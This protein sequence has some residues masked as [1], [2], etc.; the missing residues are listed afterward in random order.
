[1]SKWGHFFIAKVSRYP[2]ARPLFAD[3]LFWGSSGFGRYR[4]RFCPRRFPLSGTHGYQTLRH[5]GVDGEIARDDTWPTVVQVRV[6]PT[7]GGCTAARNHHF[8]PAPFSGHLGV[9]PVPT[10]VLPFETRTHEFA[11][12]QKIARAPWVRPGLGGRIVTGRWVWEF[13]TNVNWQGRSQRW[14]GVTGTR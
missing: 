14:P 11:L 6:R 5:W 8:L 13:Y 9:W 12:F 3:P 4:Q 7:A 1:M 10:G 2:L